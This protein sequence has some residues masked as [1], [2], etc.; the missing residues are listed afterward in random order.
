M[1]FAVN[2]RLGGTVDDIAELRRPTAGPKAHVRALWEAACAIFEVSA[3]ETVFGKPLIVLQVPSPPLYNSYYDPA[4][5]VM[6]NKTTVLSEYGD[7]IRGQLYVSDE[8]VEA[9]LYLKN[10]RR[11]FSDALHGRTELADPLPKSIL[12]EILGLYRFWDDWKPKQALDL[13]TAHVPEYGSDAGHKSARE[14]AY[15]HDPVLVTS[16]ILILAHEYGHLLQTYN[17]ES[18]SILRESGRTVMEGMISFYAD[19]G[20]PTFQ[21]IQRELAADPD[22]YR[23]WTTEVASDMAA[24]LTFVRRAGDEARWLEAFALICLVQSII[25]SY[26][27]LRH[28]ATPKSHPVSFIRMV[29]VYRYWFILTRTDKKPLSRIAVQ[30]FLCLQQIQAGLRAISDPTRDSFR[31]GVS[32]LTAQ[33]GTLRPSTPIAEPDYVGVLLSSLGILGQSFEN[34]GQFEQAEPFLREA[35][36]VAEGTFGS[37]HVEVAIQLNNLARLYY[38]S[39]RHVE[40]EPLYRRALAIFEKAFG[41]K[42]PH[43]A[44]GLN[45]L[46]ACLHSTNRRSEAEALYRRA[47]AIDEDFFG[48]G[49]PAVARDLNN[50]GLL[51]EA[52][53]QLGEAE[54]VMRRSIRIF[55][56]S[57]GPEHPDLAVALTG[58]ALLLQSTN[59]LTEAESLMRRA[60][61]IWNGIPGDH[62]PDSTRLLS[63]LAQLLQ[64]TGQ[65]AEAEPL[66]NEALAIWEQKLGKNHPIV[67]LAL[68]NLGLLLYSE[69]RFAEAEPLMVRALDIDERSS[70]P[71]HPDVARDLNNLALLFQATKR[72]SDAERLF[73]RALCVWERTLKESD[74]NIG[75]V[76]NNLARL[77]EDDDRLSEAQPLF[78]RAVQ[79]FLASTRLVGSEHVNFRPAVRAYAGLM[80]KMAFSPPELLARLREVGPEVTQVFME[81]IARLG[82]K[83][84]FTE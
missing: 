70:G 63:N 24:V 84:L 48:D 50:L 54:E 52:V 41:P 3:E 64:A 67:A 43:V 22:M 59:R 60:L 56:R 68:N 15:T 10:T 53:E 36:A 27:E 83:D 6:L 61:A 82:H 8:I 39:G 81:E 34:K 33:T 11:A 76:L 35:L 37:D 1:I 14:I 73:R 19:D 26:L 28:G 58:L 65:S 21:R 80:M 57:R 62:H 71:N 7:T 31:Q 5:L 32:D 13:S 17:V 72:Q 42:H 69:R 12:T 75:N 29:F 20:E 78:R 49:H 46:A 55:E 9:I 38:S 47:L 23:K 25:E 16:L 4:P 51:L 18:S 66:M 2:S 44:T 77:L 79:I 45:N 74:P 30:T 40:S